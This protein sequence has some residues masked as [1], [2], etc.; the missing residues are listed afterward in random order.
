M[1]HDSAVHT[2]KNPERAPWALKGDVT[3]NFVTNTDPRLS[4][5]R[6]PLPHT[7]EIEDVNGLE[8]ALAVSGAPGPPGP[9]GSAAVAD[10]VLTWMNL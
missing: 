4:D 3:Q 5:A 8:A 1:I 6:E 9:P 7:H 2:Y 10:T